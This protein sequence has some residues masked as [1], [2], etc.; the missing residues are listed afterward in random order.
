M[1]IEWKSCIRL[2]ITVFLTFL[3]IHYWSRFAG[4][5]EAVWGAASALIIGCVMA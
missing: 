5:A 1:K 4:F 2:G 3:A